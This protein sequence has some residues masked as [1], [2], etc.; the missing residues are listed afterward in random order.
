[1]VLAVLFVFTLVALAGDGKKYGKDLTVKEKTA[2]ADILKNPK[3]FEGKRILI[4]GEIDEVCQKMGCWIKV[5]D[6][7]SKEA[8]LFKVDDGV[9]EFPKEV[10]GKKV[11][12]EGVLFVKVSTKEELIK[13]GE[14]EAEEQGKK[15]DPS[16][17]T[18]PRTVIRIN[19]EGAVI[20]E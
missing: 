1:M 4:E 3:E 14:H 17:I 5:K 7:T 20:G 9:I 8:M 16:T 19:G 10:K 18:G 2:I 6:K 13:Q 11:K 15:F 12:A